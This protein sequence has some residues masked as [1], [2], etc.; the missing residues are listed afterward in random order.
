[1]YKLHYKRCEELF[2]LSGVKACDSFIFNLYVSTSL[3]IFKKLKKLQ[4]I[5]YDYH[6]SFLLR[7][8]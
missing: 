5:I 2:V 1:M 4:N 8:Y 3:N 7:M 6:D